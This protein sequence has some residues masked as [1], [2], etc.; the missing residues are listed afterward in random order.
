MCNKRLL[1]LE[2]RTL[3]CVFQAKFCMK[4][5]LK[6]VLHASH[7]ST[8]INEILG[9][10]G[11]PPLG[12]RLKRKSF[13]WLDLYMV[14]TC[15]SRK[16]RNL[17]ELDKAYPIF[18][19]IAPAP[20]TKHNQTKPNIKPKSN[21]ATTQTNDKKMKTKQ[22]TTKTKPEQPTSTNENLTT[23]QHQNPKPKAHT[24]N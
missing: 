22:S 18:R 14:C 21:Q 4:S 23:K 13:G 6:S 8:R 1:H 9:E 24:A 10:L 3:H 19:G 11:L 15:K 5:C 12:R 7:S 16:Y 20:K 17:Y 2:S